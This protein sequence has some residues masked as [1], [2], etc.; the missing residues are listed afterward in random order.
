MPYVP[1][2]EM[3]RGLRHAGVFPGETAL[4]E[5]YTSRGSVRIIHVGIRSVKVF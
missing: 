5:T 1:P 2:Q 3:N 4:P